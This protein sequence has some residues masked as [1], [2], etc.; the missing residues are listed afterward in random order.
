MK[1]Q[2]GGRVAPSLGQCLLEE[3]SNFFCIVSTEVILGASSFG[4]GYTYAI[5]LGAAPYS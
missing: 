3:V 5:F 2:Y 1:E 4:L